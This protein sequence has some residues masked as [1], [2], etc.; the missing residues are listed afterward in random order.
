MSS[1]KGRSLYSPQGGSSARKHSQKPFLSVTL[2]DCDIQT[3]AAGGPGGQHQN[4]SNTGVRI[5]HRDSGARGEARDSRSQ[6]ENKK[7]AFRRMVAHPK[8]KIWLNRQLWYHG[9]LPESRVAE[10]MNHANLRVEGKKN[11]KW[12]P[13]EQSDRYGS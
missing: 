2:N 7:A 6:H 10:D 4:T 8:F 13:I 12:V 3:F 5:I 11:G 9:M 1:K